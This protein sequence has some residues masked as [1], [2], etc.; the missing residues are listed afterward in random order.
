MENLQKKGCQR[1]SRIP[2]I[3]RYFIKISH[4]NQKKPCNFAVFLSF[5]SPGQFTGNPQGETLP[6]V[7]CCP[8]NEVAGNWGLKWL[9]FKTGE[10]Y[11]DYYCTTSSS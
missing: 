5:G 8:K 2:H 10:I 4:L 6:G 9:F 11:G 3:N 1:R 7:R